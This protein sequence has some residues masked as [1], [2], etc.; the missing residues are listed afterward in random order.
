MK[1]S[2]G[3]LSESS[4]DKEV[5]K[6]DKS[7]KSGWGEMSDSSDEEK[8][9]EVISKYK[10][11]EKKHHHHKEKEEIS[12][13]E[14]QQEEV[15]PVPQ[16]NDAASF[17]PSVEPI[18]S[19]ENENENESILDIHGE[20]RVQIDDWGSWDV[21]DLKGWSIKIDEYAA[22]K[23]VGQEE[24]EKNDSFSSKKKFRLRKR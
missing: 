13:P 16:M 18:D 12:K 4:S 23:S 17:I 19:N 8:E 10:K 22:G 11:K 2:W 14:Y 5:V 6:V 21:N 20:E 24:Q 3:K 9:K 7:K 1:S 15:Q